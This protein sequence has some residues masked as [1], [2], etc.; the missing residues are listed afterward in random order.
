MKILKSKIFLSFPLA[1]LSLEIYLGSLLGF[2]SFKLFTGKIP[3]LAFNVGSYRL[4]FHHWLYGSA[5]LIPAL[6]YNFLPFPQF[7]LG[8][9][10][11]VIFQG[12][13]CYRDWYRVIVK[14]KDV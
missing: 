11:G 9:L 5:I 2:F 7:S 4:H 10:G 12:I 3:S 14:Q 6:Y 13:Y 8:F 1:L